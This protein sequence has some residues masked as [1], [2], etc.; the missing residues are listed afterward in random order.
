[1]HIIDTADSFARIIL[2]LALLAFSFILVGIVLRFLS[3]PTTHNRTR[4]E[5]EEE[6]LAK[7]MPRNK[8]ND[9]KP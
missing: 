1:M 2:A 6:Q 7:L 5:L 3:R 8:P 4:E 9:D